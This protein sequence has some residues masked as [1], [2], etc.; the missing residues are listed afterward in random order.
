MKAMDGFNQ[1]TTVAWVKTLYFNVIAG[2]EDYRRCRIAVRP[3]RPSRLWEPVIP[4]VHVSPEWANSKYSH[5]D[6]PKGSY[7]LTLT[8]VY[9]V[10]Q[11]EPLPWECEL[12]SAN[13][14]YD[15]WSVAAMILGI[16]CMPCAVQKYMITATM[17]V[18]PLARWGAVFARWLTALRRCPF[19]AGTGSD[20]PLGYLLRK[21]PSVCSRKKESAD[22]ASQLDVRQNQLPVHWA[23]DEHGKLSRQQW[24]KYFFRALSAVTTR[25][26]D[27]LIDS[28][29]LPSIDGWWKSRWGWAP[30]GSTS[31][32]ALIKTIIAADAR[33]DTQTRGGKKAAFEV[34][35]NDYPWTILNTAP[36]DIGRGS[37]KPE[38]GAKQRPLIAHCD[39]AFIIA[40]YASL[41]M[42]KFMNVDGMV[43]KQTPAD[44]ARWVVA[45][46]QLRN[47]WW[48]SLDYSAFNEGHEQS[49]L[50]WLDSYFSRTWLHAAIEPTIALQKALAADWV[51]DTHMCRFMKS[52]LG[53]H[54]MFGGLWSGHRNT[55]RDNT[56]LHK[57][58]ADIA[59][60]QMA[61]ID[62]QAALHYQAYCGDDEDNAHSS[63]QSALLY[64][65]VHSINGHALKPAKQMAGCTHEF[66]QR[67]IVPGRHPLRPLWAMLA[68]TAS[69]N[70]YKEHFTW[71]SPSIGA[72]SDNCWALHVRGMPLL[73]ARRLAM[74]TLNG[75]M[76]VPTADGWVHLEW[77][78]YR[79]GSRGHPL[80]ST[81]G[82]ACI[83]PPA[84][85][86][87]V[88]PTEEVPHLATLAWAEKI[89]RYAPR[90]TEGQVANYKRELCADSMGAIYTR[91]RLDIQ[92]RETLQLWPR[93]T[94]DIPVGTFNG[95]ALR[96]L[97]LLDIMPMMVAQPG[98]R[99][100]ATVDEVASRFELDAR[101]VNIAGGFSEV[102]KH[103]PPGELHKYEEPQESRLIDY[104]LYNTDDAITSW[105][106]NTTAVAMTAPRRTVPPS[107]VK[108]MQWNIT[109]IYAPNLAG[110]STAK[111][112]A[113][114]NGKGLLD[115]D[116][117]LSNW[118]WVRDILRKAKNDITAMPQGIVYDLVRSELARTGA[119]T[120]VWQV[121]P[122]AW[123]T[124]AAARHEAINLYVV[125]PGLAEL[126]LRGVSRWWDANVVAKRY[127]RWKQGA[128]LQRL[129]HV[130]NT[131]ELAWCQ[132][133]KTI[134]LDMIV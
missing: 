96:P 12:M 45:S 100:P 84:L 5:G 68:Q 116:D 9:E 47:V 21:L 18:V 127:T 54:R 85:T 97:P 20:E 126:Q 41:H 6:V 86:P 129:Q 24:H 36:V 92:A 37:T 2:A 10:L 123:V 17:H 25:V 70:W 115:G 29:R 53:E 35:P 23:V 128:E 125:D 79:N 111:L 11:R 50:F 3:P 71:Y 134:T 27:G 33:L 102:L 22:W 61:G 28:Q 14:G 51:S 7:P 103:V 15:Q 130:L 114:Q 83:E 46:N 1:A 48:L 95:G 133:R 72:I 43:G 44:V 132:A 122:D 60:Q 57:I 16:N 110:K 69:G 91:Q 66:L 59:M 64:Y 65:I 98:D 49:S 74:V 109:V 99:R 131:T 40:S 13:E 38:P 58:Y 19:M 90:A 67:I 78:R 4:H 8:T 73:W 55:A 31:N 34:M 32:K 89:K 76:R 107:V 87:K 52:P 42:E 81:L 124:P 39:E 30:S 121:P 120:V 80:W 93:R 94:S 118:T 112:L 75:I 113:M 101:L 77:W 63:W 117:I 106:K 82:G 56:I 105:A 119:N 26:V 108:T 104:R 62:G 88:A